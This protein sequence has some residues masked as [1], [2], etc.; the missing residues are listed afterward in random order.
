MFLCVYTYIYLYLCIFVVC[1]HTYHALAH[2]HR[3]KLLSNPQL[4]RNKEKAQSSINNPWHLNK[5]KEPEK[6]DRNKKAEC[7]LP[8]PSQRVMDY[9]L[10]IVPGCNSILSIFLW[11]PPF[12]KTLQYFTFLLSTKETLDIQSQPALNTFFSITNILWHILLFPTV[13]W[14][15]RGRCAISSHPYD[16]PF[17]ELYIWKLF[18]LKKHATSRRKQDIFMLQSCSWRKFCTGNI[19]T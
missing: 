6:A 10:T 2:I 14:F 3:G 8:H 5:F 11:K 16:K 17:T 12:C 13:P 18:V 9:T 4:K 19:S 7:G 15:V 1:I